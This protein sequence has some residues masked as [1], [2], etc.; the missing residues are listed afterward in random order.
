MPVLRHSVQLIVRLR[1]SFFSEI[2]GRWRWYPICSPHGRRIRKWL[3]RSGTNDSCRNVLAGDYDVSASTA[4]T[5]TTTR[6]LNT[7][8][9]FKYLVGGYGRLCIGSLLHG[10]S[11]ECPAGRV[12]QP[13]R[14]VGTVTDANN[15]IV[16]QATAVLDGHGANNQR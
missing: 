16:S 15:D 12:F 13:G 8:A 4:H 5:Q 11:P 9:R 10:V 14:I 2:A 3:A 7:H 6:P 1:Q